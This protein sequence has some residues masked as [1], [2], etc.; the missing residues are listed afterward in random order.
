MSK[1]QQP[2]L[3]HY[4]EKLDYNMEIEPKAV[5]EIFEQTAQK[6]PH[7]PGFDFMGKKWS[8]G[9]LNDQVQALAAALQNHGIGPGKK[10]GLLLPNSP[11]YLVSYYAILKTG[12]TVV[13]FNPLYAKNEVGNQIEDSDTEIMITLDLAMLYDKVHEFLG[14]T[15]LKKIIVCAMTGILPFPKNFLFPLVKR[16]ELAAINW[17]DNHLNWDDLMSE[18]GDFKPVN[19]TPKEDVAVLQYTG[20][21]TGTPKG[22]MLS[23]ANIYSNTIQASSWFTGVRVGEERMMGVLPFFHVFAMIVVLNLSVRNAAEIIAMPRFDMKDALK[24]ITKKKPTLFPAV[25]A[26]Y[27]GIMNYKDLSKYDLSSIRFCISG[28]APLPVEV[29]KGFEQLTGCALVEGYGL[30]EASPVVACNPLEGTNKAGSIGLPLPATKIEIIS[31]EDNKTEMSVGEPG[32]LCVRGPQVMMGYYKRPEETQ[33]TLR[34]G[35]RL[36]TGDVAYMDEDGYVFI[37]DRIKDLIITNGYNVYP[38]HVEEAI[39]K[40]EGVEECIVGG[41]PDDR[42][43][44]VVKAWIKMKKGYKASAEQMRNFL[45]DHLSNYELPREIEFR[46]KELPKTMIGKLSR[47][48]IIAEEMEKRKKS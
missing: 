43:G 38:R 30:T 21:T 18:E 9:D 42:R 41:L 29:K 14:K 17:D 13:N 22:A 39:H 4:P 2:W 19:I 15:S 32:E 25:P 6:Y 27:S 10:V 36:H 12:A 16:K 31:R 37:I 35:G 8:Y 46:S 7:R 34:D 48:D 26:I 1:E 28:G 45:K 40:F 47:K 5:H 11:Y 20:G 23:H 33:K 24:N 3:K 44:E